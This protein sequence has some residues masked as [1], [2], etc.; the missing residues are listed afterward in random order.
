[1]AAFG[2]ADPIN[3]STLIL[4]EEAEAETPEGGA[5]DSQDEFGPAFGFGDIIRM[6][7]V[8]GAVLGAIY[9]VFYVLR[10]AS[11]G[12]AG[13]SPLI[14]V[15]GSRQ[16]AG[17]KSLHLVSVGTRIYLV[18]GADGGVNLVA[19]IED[20]ESVD[21]IRLRA[22]QAASRPRQ[23]FAEAL[24]AI[25]PSLGLGGNAG[26]GAAQG[27]LSKTVLRRQRDRLRRLG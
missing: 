21:D 24:S 4:D 16:L 18:G 8:L 2:Q 19:E 3:E 13:D 23:S 12:G 5:L 11:R 6:I 10:R 20:Q 14:E 25:M 15:I 26:G 27:G 22:S 9:G 1:M 17:G 7:V